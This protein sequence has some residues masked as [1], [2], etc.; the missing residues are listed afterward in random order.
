V[1]KKNAENDFG[2][3]AIYKGSGESLG[4]EVIPRLNL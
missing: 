1:G 4:A 2:V 3:I